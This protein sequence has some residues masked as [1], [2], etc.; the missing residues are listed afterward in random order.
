MA[1][2]PEIFERDALPE[3]KRFVHDYLVETRGR[4]SPGFGAVLNNPE[5][6]YRIAFLGSHIRFESE[7]PDNV[8]ELVALTASV[9]MGG[10]YELAIHARDAIPAGVAQ[11][12]V[13]AVIAQDELKAATE[14]ESI[15]VALVRELAATH[16]L[17]DATFAAARA[18]FGDSAIV[19]LI[20]TAS[21]YIM[22]AFVHNALLVGR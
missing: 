21:Y 1:R 9:E 20:A 13:D 22:L 14:E 10:V 5:V 18:R 19:D 7:L 6:A 2:L 15:A 17:E 4:V 8:R 16:G 12:T 11:A 3:D